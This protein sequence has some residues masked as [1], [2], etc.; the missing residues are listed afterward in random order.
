M[1]DLGA[2][3]QNSHLTLSI[4]RAKP[5]LYLVVMQ[6]Q[7]IQTREYV[8]IADDEQKA[9]EL[10]AQ[11]H[12]IAES[13]PS[14]METL[15][16]QVVSVEEIVAEERQK[17]NPAVGDPVKEL[18]CLLEEILDMDNPYHKARELRGLVKKLKGEN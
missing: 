16:S 14:T 2:I 12:F 9:A 1:K 17:S 15:E 7:I 5:M 6:D 13:E 3:F 4:E 8:V 11:G 10:V 18:G